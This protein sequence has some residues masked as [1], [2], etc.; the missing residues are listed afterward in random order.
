MGTS[1]QE[2]S[3]ELYMPH[4]AVPFTFGCQTSVTGNFKQ[5][6]AD[7][8]LGFAFAQEENAFL[9]TMVR[10]KAIER[11]A[12][13]TCITRQGG[14]LS[15]GGSGLVTI[16]DNT[17]EYSSRQ[18][19]RR[20]LQHMQEQYHLEPMSFTRIVGDNGYYSMPLSNVFLGEECITCNDSP[21]PRQNS[22]RQH[23]LD[24]F[25][26]GKGV[27]L[28]SG[29]TDTYLNKASLPIFA[30]IWNRMTGIPL[31]SSQQRYTY[32]QFR[33]M[34]DITFVF[35]PNATLTIPAS[36]YMEGVPVMDADTTNSSSSSP[37]IP[38]RVKP[39]T[40]YRQLILR[41]YFDDPTGA[42]LGLNAMHHYD[43]LYDLHDNRIGLARSNCGP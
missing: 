10:A 6:Y 7:G 22:A 26:A 18:Q 21:D 31:V 20:Q 29:T 27:I 24:T 30:N 34:P 42:V 13:A 17:N 39:W 23:A 40:G 9:K 4:L 8:I 12:F 36:A 32:D 41:I 2:E 3:S 43:I 37:S 25:R 38:E 11:P 1:D 28:D 15:L 33:T 16:S 5:Q 19:G 35:E 14:T